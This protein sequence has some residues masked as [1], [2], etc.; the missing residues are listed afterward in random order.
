MRVQIGRVFVEP[1]AKRAVELVPRAQQ[2]RPDLI[3]HEVTELAAAAH[4]G[5][6]MLCTASGF[7]RRPIH[8]T[9]GTIFHHP[10]R[11]REGQVAVA[12]SG[13]LMSLFPAPSAR[14]NDGTTLL[15]ST[16]EVPARLS[17]G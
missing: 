16:T 5:A 13:G 17:S 1:A 9:L 10:H 15:R 2:W 12:A 8:L 14:G 4:T 7:C 6:I 11:H 3:V